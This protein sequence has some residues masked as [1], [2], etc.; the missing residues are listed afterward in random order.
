MTTKTNL[1]QR[2]I[3]DPSDAVQIFSESS[4][5]TVPLVLI[6]DDRYCLSCLL[7]VPSGPY[8]IM[9][10]WGR[11][12]YENQFANPGLQCAAAYNRVAY[13]VTQ[14]ACT[15]NA[16]IK[17]C[18]TA[19]DVM[20]D[21]DLTLIFRIGPAPK[22]V[23][24][25]VYYLGASRFDE[26]LFSAVEEGIRHLI[27]ACLH[28]EVY[29]LRG[30]S[31][32]RVRKTLIE[33]NRKFNSFGVD[34]Q[35]CAI[36]DVK[37]KKDLQDLLQETTNFKSKIDNAMKQQKNAM[38]EID[39]KQKRDLDALEQQN[40]REIQD[41]QAR[42]QRMEIN[43]K[44]QVLETDA[45]AEVAITKARETSNVNETRA[46]GQKKVARAEGLRHAEE[47]LAN[48]KA[49]DAATRIKA[50]QEAKSKVFESEQRL[51]AAKAQAEALILQAEAEEKAAES[52]RLTREYELR[53]AK[54]QVLESL[55]RT[56]NL[57]ISG[58]QGD[59]LLNAILD[60]GILV[61]DISLGKKN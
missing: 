58:E 48:V 6:P 7:T 17:S 36:T 42:R 30:N 33:L 1:I 24:K 10:K 22:D 40:T 12:I 26:F 13:C 60:D 49:K 5:D 50:S 61:G 4:G 51:A 9:H 55:A 29:E 19:D 27:R 11:D 47:L 44:Q 38:A 34:F 16:P 37:F 56:S 23:K 15:Y 46:A 53:M 2:R 32:Q 14:Q 18:P 54:T 28:T 39:F 8:C 31:D 41:L 20:V 3:G 59:R 21:C 43:R 25:F 45:D 57:V 35:S 52:M